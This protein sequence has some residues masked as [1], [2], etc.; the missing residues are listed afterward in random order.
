MVR[1]VR[2]PDQ[3]RCPELVALWHEVQADAMQSSSETLI[4]I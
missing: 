1:A 3:F 2:E 4:W